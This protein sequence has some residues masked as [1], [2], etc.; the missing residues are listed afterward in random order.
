M[1]RSAVSLTRLLP[2][3]DSAADAPLLRAFETTR[4]DG[5]FE[6]LVR[7]HGPMVLAACKRVLGNRADAEDAFQ[8]VF[9]VLARKAST[10]RGN[11]A[12]WLYAV[13]VRTA[14]GVRIMRE[15]RRKYETRVSARSEQAVHP[16]TDHD[17]AE[18][19]DE[20]LARLPEHYRLAVVLCELRGLSRAQA[21]TELGIP[22]G[23]LSSRLAT[24]KRK[25]AALLSARGLA[26]AM[27][28]ALFAPASVSAGLVE[29]AVSAVRGTAG[30]VA[31]AAAS[32]VVKAMLYD[33]LRA[34]ALAA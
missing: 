34:V 3:S 19:I 25:L 31:S 33:Q 14:R 5:A 23:T 15:R 27:L 17:L 4:S 28:V 11:L 30:P 9:L 32:A 6:E 2:T 24:A 13:A 22:E 18:V 12:G 1:P 7:R 20:E 21:A 29:S 10:V 8:A 26:P 16:E